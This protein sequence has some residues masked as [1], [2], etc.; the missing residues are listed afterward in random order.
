MNLIHDL[1]ALGIGVRNLPDPIRI[2]SSNPDDP[3]AQLAVAQLAVVLALFGQMERTYTLE[4]AAHARAVATAKGRR[5]GR[6]FAVAEPRESTGSVVSDQLGD[7]AVVMVQSTKPSRAASTA[8]T[9]GSP[10]RAC[11]AEIATPACSKR[12]DEVHRVMEGGVGARGLRRHRL[13]SVRGQVAVQA[14]RRTGGS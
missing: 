5:I 12:F 11:T 1:T 9:V 7:D 3:M 6:P 14:P 2:D 13:Q 4:R 8:H 10:S